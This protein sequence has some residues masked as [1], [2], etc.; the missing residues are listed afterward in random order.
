MKQQSVRTR[1]RVRW[2]V[3]I[4]VGAAVG[5]VATMLLAR[6]GGIPGGTLGALPAGVLSGWSTLAFIETA[7]VLVRLWPMNAAETRE[8]ATGEDPGRRAARLVAVI[9]S[10][11]SL[12]AVVVV[13]VQT[14]G[15]AGAEQIVLASIA[16]L[17]VVASWM[18]IHVNY[19]LHYAR[20]YYETDETGAPLGGIDFNQHEPPEYTDFIYFSVGLGMTYQVAD[21]DVTRNVIRRIVIAQTL[22]AYLFGAGILAVAI[23][24][25]AGLGY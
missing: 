3:A 7:A 13:I 6:P 17:S 21:T 8:H 9:G 16:M 23:N 20:A 25:V 11:V 22:L 2:A 5:V 1:A 18:L 24:L 14:R 10:I 15:A 19:M 12:A 4:A